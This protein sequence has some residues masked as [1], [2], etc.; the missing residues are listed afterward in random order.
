MTYSG[1]LI[2]NDFIASQRNKLE[3][4]DADQR[5][6]LMMYRNL[7]YAGPCIMCLGGI[8][9]LAALVLTLEARDTLGVRVVVQQT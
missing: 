4:Y 5:Q 7:L 9:I 8:V 1:Y 2:V 6:T 3:E